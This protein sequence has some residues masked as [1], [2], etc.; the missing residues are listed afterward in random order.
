MLRYLATSTACNAASLADWLAAHWH[1]ADEAPWT[2]AQAV[3][4]LADLERL[5]PQLVQSPPRALLQP[6]DLQPGVERLRQEE[7]LNE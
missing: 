1:S 7:Q 6:L 4:L 2:L 5:C 3:Q